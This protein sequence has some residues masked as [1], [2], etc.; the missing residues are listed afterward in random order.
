MHRPVGHGGEID[1]V[2]EEV[3]GVLEQLGNAVEHVGHVLINGGPVGQA[4]NP[5]SIFCGKTGSWRVR[6]V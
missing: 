5:L 2:V 1:L 6:E 3:G 4:I